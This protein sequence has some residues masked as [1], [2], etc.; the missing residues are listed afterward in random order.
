MLDGRMEGQ[1]GE[2]N[3]EKGGRRINC[4]CGVRGCT[5]DKGGPNGDGCWGSRV[6]MMEVVMVSVVVIKTS[7]TRTVLLTV[8]M[9]KVTTEWW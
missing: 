6:L 5:D 2:G 7:A 8:M 4:D 3:M 9:G 1:V